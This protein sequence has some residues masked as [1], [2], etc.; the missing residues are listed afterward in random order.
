LH[1]AGVTAM[2]VASKFTDIQP[3]K[4]KIIYE[5]IAH[6]KLSTDAIKA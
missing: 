1:I 5:K 2:F 6:K 3:L 4:L